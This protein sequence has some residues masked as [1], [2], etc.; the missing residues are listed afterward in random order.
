MYLILFL[1][2]IYFKMYYS[3]NGLIQGKCWSNHEL[4]NLQC[5]IAES[6]WCLFNCEINSQEIISLNSITV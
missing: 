1:Q 2:I 3:Y 6:G 5:K 4:I